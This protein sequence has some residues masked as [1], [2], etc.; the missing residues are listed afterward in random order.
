MPSEYIPTK[1]IGDYRCPFCNARAYRA[2]D[3]Y[4]LNRFADI[5]TV[6][7]DAEC[8]RKLGIDAVKAMYSLTRI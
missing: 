6:T 5:V 1:P 8:P 2:T 3:I 7:H 4:A